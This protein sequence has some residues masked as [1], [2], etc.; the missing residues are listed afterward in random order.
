MLLLEALPRDEPAR[1][2]KPTVSMCGKEV[3]QG[4]ATGAIVTCMLLLVIFGLTVWVVTKHL[5]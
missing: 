1:P 4:G 3:S 5:G 2:L